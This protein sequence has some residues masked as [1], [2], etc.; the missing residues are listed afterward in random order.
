M[1]AQQNLFHLHHSDDV[2]DR[3]RDLMPYGDRETE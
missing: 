1:N 3:G 2:E